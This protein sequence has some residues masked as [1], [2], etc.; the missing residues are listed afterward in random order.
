MYFGGELFLTTARLLIKK[1]AQTQRARRKKIKQREEGKMGRQ[2]SITNYQ[3]PMPNAH[4]PLITDFF[5]TI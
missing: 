3:L 1:T 4:C 2:L 5:V